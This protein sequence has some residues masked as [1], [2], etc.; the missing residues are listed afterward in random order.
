MNKLDGDFTKQQV[1]LAAKDQRIADLESVNAHLMA[2]LNLSNKRLEMCMN[3]KQPDVMKLLNQRFVD[4]V[5]LVGDVMQAK[6]L[7][8]LS[9][10]EYASIRQ[11]VEGKL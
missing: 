8:T 11:S 10:E 9:Q 7:T 6:G 3:V 5:Q 4:G 1:E 2:S